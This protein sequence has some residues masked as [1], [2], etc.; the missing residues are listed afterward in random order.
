MPLVAAIVAAVVLVL[1]G[2]GYL[3]V[4]SRRQAAQL[5][6]TMRKEAERARLEAEKQAA[7]A[8]AKEAARP[9]EVV[10][11]VTLFVWSEPGAAEVEATWNGGKKQGV[12]AFNFDVPKNTKVHFEFRKQGFLPNPY[13]SDVFADASQTV[14]AKLI[15]E[16]KVAA[17]SPVPPPRKGKKDKKL[18]Q[19]SEETIKID[20]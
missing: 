2:I 4:D 19:G 9:A 15:P 16:P 20:F 12:T 10:Q 3:V 14:Q 8:R 17:A 13:V 18:D 1:G 7:A 11:N 6:E 5:A